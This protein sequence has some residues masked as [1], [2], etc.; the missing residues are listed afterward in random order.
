[1]SDETPVAVPLDIC[2]AHIYD[3]QGETTLQVDVAIKIL[4]AIVTNNGLEKF[5]SVNTKV[6]ER[7][8]NPDNL[9]LWYVLRHVGFYKQGERL[10]CPNTVPVSTIS[11]VLDQLVQLQDYNAKIKSGEIVAPKY[12]SPRASPAQQQPQQQDTTVDT[13]MTDQPAPQVQ[14]QPPQQEAQPVST[15]NDA[16]PPS[17]ASS[18]AQSTG[19]HSSTTKSV[20]NMTAEE[21]K[22]YVTQLMAQRKAAAKK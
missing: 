2:L 5:R 14:E 16:P 13:S 9:A 10:I 4:Q 3:S 19:P 7:I 18:P 1:M 11:I 15:M 12:T 17:T 6:L 21:K 8:A 22:A 20:A